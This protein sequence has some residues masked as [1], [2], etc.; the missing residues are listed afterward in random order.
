M[1]KLLGLTA[2][3]GVAS[4]LLGSYLI[5]PQSP[6]RQYLSS[7]ERKQLEDAA[8]PFG[9]DGDRA[10]FAIDYLGLSPDYV[11]KVIQSWNNL[12]PSVRAF[13]GGSVPTATAALVANSLSSQDTA[14]LALQ[15]PNLL[16]IHAH[17]NAVFSFPWIVDI[18]DGD[19]RLLKM[20]DLRYSEGPEVIQGQTMTLYFQEDN[21]LSPGTYG[22][23]KFAREGFA[24]FATNFGDQLEDMD[25]A[26]TSILTEQSISAAVTIANSGMTFCS[27][28]SCPEGYFDAEAGET[29]IFYNT[30]EVPQY[31]FSAADNLEA[32]GSLT[33]YGALSVGLNT[34]KSFR[35]RHPALLDSPS[36]PLTEQGYLQLDDVFEADTNFQKYLYPT[37]YPG[38][39][40]PSPVER[41]FAWKEYQSV[42]LVPEQTVRGF[43]VATIG[44]FH[45]ANFQ[46]L[47]IL[48]IDP[49][50]V[51]L[52][53]Q[54]PEIY[55]P[56]KWN[57]GHLF[58]AYQ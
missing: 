45:P 5:G 1:L 37:V 49:S 16:W 39:F 4:I 55:T 43:G 25:P 29:C 26:T 24:F 33:P 58:Q 48:K 6:I 14:S 42:G 47:S 27:G 38:Y 18:Q 20:A 30:Q 52:L 13:I 8:S 31:C 23:R 22:K 36:L 17:T 10:A 11:S 53:V 46:P 51:G 12:S 41:T 56:S 35:D 15:Y 3:G 7:V 40:A 2:V 50:I 21:L 57:Q 32:L 54:D 44:N 28:P 34:M 9:Q 19:P